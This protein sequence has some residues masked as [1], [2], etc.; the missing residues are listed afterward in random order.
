LSRYAYSYRADNADRWLFAAAPA[1]TLE[2]LGPQL[3]FRFATNGGS[4]LHNLRTVVVDPQ[5]RLYRQFD[6]NKWTAQELALAIT[7]AARLSL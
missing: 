4:F 7:E 5:G 6:G 1:E 3:D 2:L